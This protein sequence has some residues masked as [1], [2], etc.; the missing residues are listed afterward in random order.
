MANEAN[1]DLNKDKKI[2]LI[3]L[4]FTLWIQICG[5]SANCECPPNPTNQPRVN[6]TS[7]RNHPLSLESPQRPLCLV[8]L[9]CFCQSCHRGWQQMGKS[10]LG[11]E[12]YTYSPF[13]QRTSILTLVT[14]CNPKFISKSCQE[15][16]DCHCPQRLSQGSGGLWISDLSSR[17]CLVGLVTHKV[18]VGS[19]CYDASRLVWGTMWVTVLW[20][21]QRPIWPV[22]SWHRNKTHL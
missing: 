11:L 10:F 9:I 16:T 1:T 6:V 15:T 2:S 19:T 14:L 21:E 3:V 8:R 17:G 20:K 12:P 7:I 18:P 4:I 5:L 22:C 13:L